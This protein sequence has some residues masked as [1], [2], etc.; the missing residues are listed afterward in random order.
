MTD[1][2]A[3]A[4]GIVIG[5]FVGWL[6]LTIF[7]LAAISRAQERMQRKVRYWQAQTARARSEN[8]RLTEFL[9]AHGPQPNPES[10]EEQ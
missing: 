3:L 9:D 1:I 2:L 4:A 10:W 6:L 8:E 7:A 5:L